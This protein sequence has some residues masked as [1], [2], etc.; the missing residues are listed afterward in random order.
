MQMPLT[1]L[2]H[3]MTNGMPVYPGTPSAILEPFA[4]Q[5]KDGFNELQIHITT[6]T[7][8]HIDCPLHIYKEGIDTST[9]V[10]RFYGS[11]VMF[12]CSSSVDEIPMSVF[13]E[14]EELISKTDFILIHTGW[15]RF[16]SKSDYFK[17]F[18][19]LSADAARYLCRFKLK[20]TGIDAPSFDRVDSSDLP[21]HHE[22]LSK[23][24]ILIENLTNLS[25]LPVSGFHF[26]CLPLKIR[27]GDGSPVRAVAIIN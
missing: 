1:D 21:I 5:Q 8:T 4:S 2:T 9:D 18:P 7:G 20:G 19:V 15:D 13:K 11:A 27:N 16:W 3:L 10:N 24:I 17:D 14:K 23:G 6:H 26:S 22:F 12:D 25:I